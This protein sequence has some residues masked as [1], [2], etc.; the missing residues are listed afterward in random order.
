MSN[1]PCKYETFSGTCLI[2]GAEI[3]DQ[4]EVEVERFRAMRRAAAAVASGR[5]PTMKE[6]ANVV[7][8]KVRS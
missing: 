2:C 3:H 7:R 8:L 4:C 1:L 6:V 5:A